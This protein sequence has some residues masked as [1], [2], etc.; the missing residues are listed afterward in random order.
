M[1]ILIRKPKKKDGKAIFELVRACAP[2][3][4]LNSMYL[5]FLVGAHFPETGAVVEQDGAIVGF[6][7]AYLLP[8]G[9]DHLFVWQV[10]VHQQERCKGLARSM[11]DDILS[12]PTC[13][14]VRYLEATVTASNEASRQLFMG[15]A[16]RRGAPC[17][18]ETFL[19]SESF[20]ETAHEEEILF[21]IGP[22]QQ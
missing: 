17:R 9:E 6:T 2:P 19:D 8:D 18:E 3:L 22:I 4:D 13:R 15:F 16:L 7:S 21:T 14:C 20:G 5:Y 1:L 10:A 11:L 12:R